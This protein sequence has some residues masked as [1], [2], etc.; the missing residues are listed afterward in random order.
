MY[1]PHTAEPSCPSLRYSA[2]SLP[3]VVVLPVP[4]TPTIITTSGAIC[5]T[6]SGVATP[7]QHSL[8]LNLQQPLQLRAALDPLMQPALPQILDDRLRRRAANIRPQQNHLQ[9][10]QRRLV[11]LARQRKH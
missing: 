10:G 11:D 2:A 1:P 9:L 3:V 6:G 7:S 8:Q 4:L 5:T